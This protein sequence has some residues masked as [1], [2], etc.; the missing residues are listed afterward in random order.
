MQ[1]SL[2]NFNL[3]KYIRIIYPNNLI[4]PE[5]LYSLIGLEEKNFSFKQN[6]L[7]NPFKFIKSIK[8]IWLYPL[9]V[10]WKTVEL[11]NFP[12][13]TW[14]TGYCYF[15]SS[16][17]ILCAPVF[18]GTEWKGSLTQVF[19]NNAEIRSLTSSNDRNGWEKW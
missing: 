7:N 17:L 11:Q 16:S 1:A 5:N 6:K 3:Y 19:Y 2:Y 18:S 14:Y 4:V 10:S 13:Q 8:R 9:T 12:Q 15:Y